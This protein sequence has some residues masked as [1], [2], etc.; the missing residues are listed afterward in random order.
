MKDFI[1][2]ALA[3]TAAA[4]SHQPLQPD[5]TPR[6]PSQEAK[7]ILVFPSGDASS[8]DD[9]QMAQLEAVAELAQKRAAD[10]NNPKNPWVADL[11]KAPV[12]PK[13]LKALKEF[14]D[15][16]EYKNSALA[17]AAD[18][19]SQICQ[20]NELTDAS[21]LISEK[22]VQ[23][24][25]DTG[26]AM[27]TWAQLKYQLDDMRLNYCYRS[28]KALVAA[29]NSIKLS[30]KDLVAVKPKLNDKGCEKMY[31]AE[32]KDGAREAGIYIAG[33][34][35]GWRQEHMANIVTAIR[36]FRATIKEEPL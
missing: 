22:A 19:T 34:K 16:K 28:M 12:H 8:Y 2:L 24:L 26:R 35:M 33:C 14:N 30:V 13:V 9:E 31:E 25:M 6:L 11:H 29:A 36:K 5:K 4:C 32:V 1:F 27:A 15:N 18:V 21:E 17:F 7:K 10:Y 23:E 3:L 20:I